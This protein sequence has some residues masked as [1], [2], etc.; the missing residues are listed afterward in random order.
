VDGGARQAVRHFSLCNACARGAGA[1][2]RDDEEGGQ[3]K[4]GRG[5]SVH[6]VLRCEAG[7]GPATGER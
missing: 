2:M 5:R 4:D 7:E 1:A 3:D 6:G